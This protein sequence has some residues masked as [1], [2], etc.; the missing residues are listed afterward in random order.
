MAQCCHGL[1]LCHCAFPTCASTVHIAVDVVLA[2]A[3]LL[4]YVFA[5]GAAEKHVNL[6]ISDPAFLVAGHAVS[7]AVIKNTDTCPEVE[8]NRTTL[9]LVRVEQEFLFLLVILN[10]KDI[11]DPYNLRCS[12]CL[13]IYIY[14]CIYMYS[15]SSCV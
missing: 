2:L 12:C 4:G 10:Y 15:D 7:C 3:V 1:G 8:L 9:G 14:I 13:Y 6:V 11:V 5:T